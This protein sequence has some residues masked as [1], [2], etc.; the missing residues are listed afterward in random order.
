MLATVCQLSRAFLGGCDYSCFIFIL[1][2]ICFVRGLPHHFVSVLPRGF[3]YKAGRKPVSSIGQAHV[4]G[5]K[6]IHPGEAYARHWYVR[7]D[8][9]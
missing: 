2:L 7:K 6:E 1:S 3:I 4:V 5:P 8:F 9:P